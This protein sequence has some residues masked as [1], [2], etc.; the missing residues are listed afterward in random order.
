VKKFHFQIRLILTGN[1]NALGS[2]FFGIHLAA[3]PQVAGKIFNSSSK[4]LMIMV[5]TFA[6][7]EVIS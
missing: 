6:Q 5:F 4:T 1:I 7:L 2:V 3:T